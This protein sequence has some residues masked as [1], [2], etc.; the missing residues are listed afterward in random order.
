MRGSN[1]RIIGSRSLACETG[2]RPSAPP[3]GRR[4]PP[5]AAMRFVASCRA[6]EPSHARRRHERKCRVACPRPATPAVGQRHREP[7]AQTVAAW[8]AGAPLS[9]LFVA[10]RLSATSNRRSAP[11]I[12]T[13]W[14]GARAASATGCG[15]P[16]CSGRSARHAPTATSCTTWTS[17]AI[18]TRRGVPAS[19]SISHWPQM[20]STARA[21]TNGPHQMVLA[22]TGSAGSPGSRRGRRDALPG[23]LP[24]AHKKPRA[25]ARGYPQEIPYRNRILG[26]SGTSAKQ[27]R[28]HPPRERSPARR[29]PL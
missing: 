4:L 12:G 25:E 18:S 23:R 15:S 20:P 13:G 3:P 1:P 24:A 16:R 22:E 6:A 26:S 19:W 8:L 10:I 11:A 5:N 2:P 28:D 9:T 7:T 29:S 21:S 14:A 17:D 27:G